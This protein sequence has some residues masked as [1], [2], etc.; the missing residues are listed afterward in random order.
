M[1]GVG[2]VG[3]VGG[4]VGGVLLQICKQRGK[5]KSVM[6]FH[7]GGNG[8]VGLTYCMEILPEGR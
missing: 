6:W 4:F 2:G 3:K 1:G 5:V 8:G 7:G